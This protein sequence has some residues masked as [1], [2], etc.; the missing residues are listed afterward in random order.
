MADIMTRECC[1]T[2]FEAFGAK[3]NYE[4]RWYVLLISIRSSET[5]ARKILPD[6]FAIS[7]VYSLNLVVK[8]RMKIK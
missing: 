4:K 8:Y 6:I 7:I 2:P 1:I 5:F 3:I